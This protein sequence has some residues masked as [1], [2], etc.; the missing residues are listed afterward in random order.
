MES[1]TIRKMLSK[2]GGVVNYIYRHLFVSKN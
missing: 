1:P 2:L